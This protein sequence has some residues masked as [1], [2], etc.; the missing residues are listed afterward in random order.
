[1]HTNGRQ[2]NQHPH[3][4]LSMTRGGLCRKHDVRRPGFL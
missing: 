4:H 3:I 2:L 1:M